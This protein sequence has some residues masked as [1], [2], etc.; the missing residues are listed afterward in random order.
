MIQLAVLIA[1]AV[2]AFVL[3]RAVAA[4]NRQTGLRDAEEWYRRGRE[5]VAAGRAGDGVQAFRRASARRP[6]ER[7]YA[8]ALARALGSAGNPT[9][10]RQTLLVLRESGPEDAEV[11]LEL[12]RLAAAQS[13]VSEAL[14]FYY[15]AL[16]APWPADQVDVRRRVRMELIRFL[17]TH[18][19]RSRALSELL[20]VSAETPDDVRHQEEL[21]ELFASTGD[22]RRALEHFQRALRLAPGD[23]PALSGA[24]IAAFHLDD[25]PLAWSYLRRT[26][27]TTGPG[28][29][30]R[31]L[32]ELVLANDPLAGR[33]GAT[34]RR[35]RLV[36]A[37]DRARARL[38]ACA[39]ADDAVRAGALAL[40]SA[41]DPLRRSLTLHRVIDQDTIESG[42]DVISRAEDYGDRHCGPPVALDRA[43]TLIAHQRRTGT[44]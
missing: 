44:Q 17:A 41:I 13:D 20:A 40:Q 9:A 8:L 18:G 30:T 3:T 27:G 26:T 16:Y 31:E 25:Y 7:T 39:P 2:V 5:A 12:A 33:L 14:R 24:G 32:V 38:T 36:G 23:P 10:A 6:G 42:L 21:A 35:R 1:A 22:Q 43:L 28:A 11:N 15:N 29:E 34:E 19:Q 37:L 4:A